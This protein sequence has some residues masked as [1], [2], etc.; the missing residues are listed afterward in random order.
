MFWD[1]FVSYG[2]SIT[3][4]TGWA[5]DEGQSLKQQEQGCGTLTEW[6]WTDNF[7][8]TGQ[9]AAWFNLPIFMKAGCVERAIVSA[10]GPQISCTGEG[11]SKN[12][13]ESEKIEHVNENQENPGYIPMDWSTPNETP[14]NTQ[15]Q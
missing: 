1:D 13:Q 14:A 4:I 3:N 6:S 9:A 10:G 8:G 12:K 15:Q 2:F 11:I 7:H 5:T